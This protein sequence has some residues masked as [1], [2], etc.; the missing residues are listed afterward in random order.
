MA[1]K[2]VAGIKGKVFSIEPTRPRIQ[3]VPSPPPHKII[4][5]ENQICVLYSGDWSEKWG[6]AVF[7]TIRSHGSSLEWQCYLGSFLDCKMTKQ[8]K[9]ACARCEFRDECE[10]VAKI[11][12]TMARR[13]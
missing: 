13:R 9:P 10:Q 5:R 6:R 2:I 1:T 7:D 12:G 4:G 8:R 11:V 3:K